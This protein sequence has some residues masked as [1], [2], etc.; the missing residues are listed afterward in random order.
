MNSD[1]ITDEIEHLQKLRR[2]AEAKMNDMAKTP[3]SRL[4][5]EGQ[6]DTYTVALGSLMRV[7]N[8]V[9]TGGVER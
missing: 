8:G 2:E 3:A 7:K 6:R 4:Y 5:H 1:I 9:S